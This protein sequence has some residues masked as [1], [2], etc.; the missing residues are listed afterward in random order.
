MTEH[1]SDSTSTLLAPS[2]AVS[3][4]PCWVDLAT[5]NIAASKQFYAEML[6]WRFHDDPATPDQPYTIATVDG[7]AVAGL[8]QPAPDQPAPPSWT[9]YLA[10]RNANA[11]A[12]WVERLGGEVLLGPMEVRGQGNLLMVA[13]PSG[14][15]I[16]LWEQPPGWE[17]GAR[18]R[19]GFT[20]AELNTWDGEAADQFFAGLFGFTPEQIGDG[21]TY[22]YTSWWHEQEQILGRQRMTAEFGENMAPHWMI[23]FNADP[24]LGVDGTAARAA[25]LGGNIAI[26]PFNSAFGRVA[27]IADPSGVTFTLIDSTR[28]VE[29]EPP[30]AEVDDPY[31]D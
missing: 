25:A 9:L 16:G 31:A 17:F 30:R 8:Y 20:W 12:G 23:Y 2:G 28:R 26:R 7:W 5:T 29:V 27:A 18:M 4:M 21:E 1:A 19:G 10:V 11:T 13:D 14:G 6:G 24:R 22:D 3:G 15:V